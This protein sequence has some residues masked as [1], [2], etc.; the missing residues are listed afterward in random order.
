MIKEILLPDL[1]EGI[2][3]A[4]VSEVLVSPGKTIKADDIIL[5]LESE[6][7]SMEI[8]AETGGRVKKVLVVP[9]STVEAGQC[10][11]TLETTAKKTSTK[12]VKEKTE[13][14]IDEPK[15]TTASKKPRAPKRETDRAFAAPGVRRLSREL[16]IDLQSIKGTGPKER[17]TKEDLHSFIREKMEGA[18]EAPHPRATEIDFSQWGKIATQKLSKIKGITA[19]RMQQSWQTIPHVTQFDEADITDLHAHRQKLNKNANTKKQKVTFLPFFMKAA[20]DLLKEMPA[21]NSSLDH[22][23]ENLIFKHYFHIGFAVDTPAG[24]MVPV[25]RNVDQKNIFEISAELQDLGQRARDKKL[26]PSE[27]KGGTFT[28]SSL[29]GIGGTFFTPIIDPPQVAI[30]GLSESWWKKVYDHKNKTTRPRYILPFSLS[31]DHRVIDGAAAARFTDK[32]AETLARTDN[33]K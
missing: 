16:K 23:E 26:K 2:D 7:A 11:I 31:Y 12:R 24:L 6:K 19:R 13:Q 17:I 3:A 32:Y 27:L 25:V 10:L 15:I 33:Y 4:E 20:A 30:L 28:I 5:V 1:G 18:G 21:F 14:V 8:P 9:G 29:G 22:R